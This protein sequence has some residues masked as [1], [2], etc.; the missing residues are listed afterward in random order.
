M[1]KDHETIT[2]PEDEVQAAMQ[3][4]RRLTDKYDTGG[5]RGVSGAAEPTDKG[6]PS[7]KCSN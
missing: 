5:S 6:R 4:A 1:K 7:E 3:A 2:E